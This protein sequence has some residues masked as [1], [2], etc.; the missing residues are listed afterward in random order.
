MLVL[1]GFVVVTAGVFVGFLLEGGP[2]LLLIQPV[3]L[4]I[5]GGAAAGAL[6]IGTSPA[7]LQ[8]L[9]RQAMGA[10]KPSPFSP[11]LYLDLLQLLYELLVKA[12]KNGLI[13]LEKDLAAPH[14]SAIFAA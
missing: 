12:K 7:V 14:E 3:E 13:A 6:L 8:Q 10:V 4:M 5:I 9:V 1:V 11:A 2:L